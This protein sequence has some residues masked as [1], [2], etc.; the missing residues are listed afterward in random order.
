MLCRQN[1][2]GTGMLWSL[3]EV[4]S[5]GLCIQDPI[6]SGRFSALSPSVV[7]LPLSV[8]YYLG[9]RSNSEKLRQ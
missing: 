3:S 9:A 1:C 7:F 2:R 4:V 5:W 6:S 8:I